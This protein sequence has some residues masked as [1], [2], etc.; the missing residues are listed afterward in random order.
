MKGKNSKYN[1]AN[2]MIKKLNLMQIHLH[3]VKIQSGLVPSPSL[4]Q[5]HSLTGVMS[6]DVDLRK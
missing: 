4:L 6:L 1:I 2:T 5:K 3:E